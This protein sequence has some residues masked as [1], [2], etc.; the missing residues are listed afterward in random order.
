MATDKR[1]TDNAP[2][3]DVRTLARQGALLPGRAAFLSW[4]RCTAEVRACGDDQALL[5]HRRFDARREAWTEASYGIGLVW[6]QCHLGGRRAWWRCPVAGCGRRVA[7]LYGGDIFGCRHCQQLT[8]RTQ[9]ESPD[10]RAFRRADKLRQQLGWPPGVLN[11]HGVQPQGMQTRTYL[12]LL[13]RYLDAERA[14]LN[15]LTAWLDTQRGDMGRA[16]AAARSP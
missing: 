5:T 13:A 14:V 6:T 3:L 10:A 2:R 12:R 9:Y 8:Y 15:G 4:A 1:W 11:G 7:I 16:R